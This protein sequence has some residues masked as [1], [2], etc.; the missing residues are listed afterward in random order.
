MKEFDIQ[1]AIRLALSPYAII[2]RVNSGQFWSGKRVWDERRRQ[3]ILTDLRP[4]AGAPAGTSDLIGC[5]RSDGKFIALEVKTPTGRVRTEQE[6]FL[7]AIREAHAL[8]GVA[9]SP[10]DAIRIIEGDTNG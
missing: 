3:Y 1:N 10:E 4:V 5:R 8:C 6:R 9:R 2:L 7:A